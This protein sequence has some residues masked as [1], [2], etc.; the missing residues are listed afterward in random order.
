[1]LDIPIFKLFNF[2]KPIFKL[3]NFLYKVLINKSDAY[4]S[5]DKILNI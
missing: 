1:M 5:K 3:F 4:F 2:Y